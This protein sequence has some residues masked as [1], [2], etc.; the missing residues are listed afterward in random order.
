MAWVT[1]WGGREES[2]VTSV[3][4]TM[5]PINPLKGNSRCQGAVLRASVRSQN[6]DAKKETRGN[7]LAVRSP[8]D[9]TTV[10]P[11]LYPTDKL[12]SVSFSSITLSE[13]SAS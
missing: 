13:Q 5:S 2:M 10:R 9:G 7:I 1:R 4:E 3:P 12:P 11:Q 8:T 6:P